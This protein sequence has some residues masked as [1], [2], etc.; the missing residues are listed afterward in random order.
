MSTASILWSS[1]PLRSLARAWALVALATLSACGAE[2][3]PTLVEVSGRTVEVVEAGAG[4]VTVVF[5]SGLGDDWTPWKR[6]ARE[7]A[8]HAQVFAYSRP[9]YGDSDPSSDPRTATQ[10]V[11]D[12]RTLLEVQGHA[13]PYVLV[14]HSFGGATM[15]LFAK[16]HPEEVIGLVLVDPRHRDLSDACEDA[17]AEG[18][19]IAASA[20]AS[21]PKVQIAEIA[22]FASVSDEIEAAGTFGDH[23]VRV[24]TATRHRGFDRE[25][26]ALWVSL[27]G[28]LADEAEDGEQIVFARAGHYLQ[29]W[30]SR[31]VAREILSLVPAEE[32]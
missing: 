13:P 4:D 20:L 30:R 7:V 2:L 9:G 5:E 6:V 16:Q 26:E 22:G 12:L 18:C 8:E 27:L 17:G 14:G 24:L 29:I 15:E 25:A 19:T 3:D 32:G 31:K 28:S 1:R 10:I 21:L 11:A 23:P